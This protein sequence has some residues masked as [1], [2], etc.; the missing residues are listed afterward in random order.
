MRIRACG[1]LDAEG[2]SCASVVL[3]AT[4][5]Q[6]SGLDLATVS[7]S[8]R[9]NSF[10]S[11]TDYSRAVIANRAVT[12]QAG[13]KQ[14]TQRLHVALWYIL[15]AQNASHITTLGPKYIPKNYMEPMG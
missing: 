10:T 14:H 5:E 4:S 9:R 15:R 12:R 13:P 11:S 1:T 3:V 7:L 6:S 8:V 2:G